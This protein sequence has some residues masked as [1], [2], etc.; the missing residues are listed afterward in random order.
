[1]VG[2]FEIYGF[3]SYSLRSMAID[4]SLFLG[5]FSD[6]PNVLFWPYSLSFIIYNDQ[7]FLTWFLVTTHPLNSFGSKHKIVLDFSYCYSNKRYTIYKK[8]SY[9]YNLQIFLN[10]LF[11]ELLLGTYGK[12]LK[13]INP[14]NDIIFYF[15]QAN[16]GKYFSCAYQTRIS[17]IVNIKMPVRIVKVK[18]QLMNKID[19]NEQ[20]SGQKGSAAAI[21]TEEVTGSK[22]QDNDSG[23]WQTLMCWLSTPLC[24]QL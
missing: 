22:R 5:S 3:K 7:F 8:Q 12:F 24:L 23:G 19:K 16:F 6:L 9:R 13:W 11:E 10:A 1:M 18:L 21:S 17:T 4:T 15:F 2:W 14:V 20:L